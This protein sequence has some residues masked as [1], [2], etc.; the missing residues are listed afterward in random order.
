MKQIYD[1]FGIDTNGPAGQ[2]PIERNGTLLSPA[3][4]Q[5]LM[6][7]P[8]DSPEDACRADDS[9]TKFVTKQ[10]I[11]LGLDKHL[12]NQLL[13]MWSVIELQRAFQPLSY[14]QSAQDNP[15]EKEKRASKTRKEGEG[16]GFTEIVNGTSELPNNIF[17][18]ITDKQNFRI[19][20]NQTANRVNWT[21]EGLVTLEFQ[22]S[23]E[24]QKFDKVVLTPTSRAVS[25][26]E[27]DPKLHYNHTYALDSFHYMN[28]V[29]IFL[30]FTEPFWA[31]ENYAPIIPFNS[32]GVNGGSGT[33]DL[34]TRSSYYPSHS[35]HGNSILASYVWGMDADLLTSLSDEE[36]KNQ[37][38]DDLAKIHGPIVKQTYKEGV[39]KKWLEDDDT[40]GAFPWAYPGDIQTLLPG[41]RQD[42]GGK[43]FFAGEYTS[44]VSQLE[45]Q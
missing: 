36:L 41:L 33:S 25:R 42:Y 39:V 45:L 43:L 16:S 7:A 5:V 20:Y 15:E 13:S 38:L 44:K 1:L 11:N 40:S 18:I 34:L 12:A 14:Y 9:L 22:Q 37:A 2:F 17:K 8:A 30:A 24:I 35:F 29:K 32:S 10:L 23:N 3:S 21:Q 31:K 4:N 27:F 19:Q 28:S 6:N 26:M